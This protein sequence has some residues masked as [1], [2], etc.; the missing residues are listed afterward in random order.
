MDSGKCETCKRMCY[1]VQ[2][3]YWCISCPELLCTTC[4]KYHKALTA[5]KRLH[6]K[7]RIVI[8]DPENSTNNVHP[9]SGKYI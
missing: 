1:D 5:T 2:G 4:S 3:L 8:T 6:G 7:I 9:T